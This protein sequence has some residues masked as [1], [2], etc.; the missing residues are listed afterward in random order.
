MTAYPSQTTLGQLYTTLRE[1]QSHPDVILPGIEPVSVVTPLTLRC[2]ALDRCAIQEPYIV[3]ASNVKKSKN[4]KN[5]MRFDSYWLILAVSYECWCTHMH[6]ETCKYHTH[7]YTNAYICILFRYL[8]KGMLQTDEIITDAWAY[9]CYLLQLR[10]W[11]LK[12][13][14]RLVHQL[15]LWW[16]SVCQIGGSAVRTSGCLYGGATGYNSWT[17]S[18][19][20]IHQWCRSCCW[21]VSDPRL[22]RRHHSV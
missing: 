1:S 3:M 17:D 2:S 12:W 20:C 14:P 6:A 11:F 4:Q 8:K 10:P 7:M 5:Q 21:W 19:P 15:L 9:K 22:R 16:S 18:L 13:L